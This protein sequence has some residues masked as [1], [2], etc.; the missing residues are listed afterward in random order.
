MRHG[1]IFTRGV[2]GEADGV[3]VTADQT[4]LFAFENAEKNA[5]KNTPHCYKL[6]NFQAPEFTSVPTIAPDS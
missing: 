6:T 2:M 5:S 1:D 4:E 3:G